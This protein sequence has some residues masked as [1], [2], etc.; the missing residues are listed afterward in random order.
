MGIIDLGTIV[1]LGGGD[2]AVVIGLLHGG[3]L[4][5]FYTILVGD[6]VREIDDSQIIAVAPFEDKEQ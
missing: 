2:I 5:T 4:G 1:K 6:E 3:P